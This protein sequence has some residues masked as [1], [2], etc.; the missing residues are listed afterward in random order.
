VNRIITLVQDQVRDVEKK[1][2]KVGVGQVEFFQPILF[3][4]ISRRYF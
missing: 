1:G 4:I 3:L 2:G